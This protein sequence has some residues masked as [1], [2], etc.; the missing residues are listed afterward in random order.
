MKVGYKTQ[1]DNEFKA[2]EIHGDE[3][4]PVM[5]SVAQ[6]KEILGMAYRG[7]IG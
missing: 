4:S 6:T 3:A 7:R 2:V 1:V 5:I